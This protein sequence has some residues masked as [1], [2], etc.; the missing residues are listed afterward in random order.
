M[1]YREQYYAIIDNRRA[2]PVDKD[3]Y[4]ETHHIIPKSL[5]GSNEKGN[6][7]ALLPEEHY[8]CHC[9]LVFMYEH[10]NNHAAFVKMLHAWRFMANTGVRKSDRKR[11]PEIARMDVGASEYSA[12]RRK[13]IDTVI[14][15]IVKKRAEWFAGL[16]EEER[17]ALIKK[18]SDSHKGKKMSAETIKKI[19]EATTGK[20]KWSEEQK[21]E[22][23]RRNKI[24]YSDPARRLAISIRKKGKKRSPETI[25]KVR[26]AL[27]G[28]KQSAE[29][30]LKRTRSCKGRVWVHLGE[31]SRFIQKQELDS[32]IKQGYTPGVSEK[33]K[34]HMRTADLGTVHMHNG[35]RSIK[36]RP[37]K[38][39]EM[40]KLGF[41]LGRVMPSAMDKISTQEWLAALDG[42]TTLVSLY[43]K[44][45]L[46]RGYLQTKSSRES[47]KRKT[48]IDIDA[49]IAKNKEKL[50]L[51]KEAVE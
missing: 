4:T 32:F 12:I 8:K 3:V 10:E 44:L 2:N 28:R 15:H 31:I 5:G 39:D 40:L 43:K 25:E 38:V 1:T 17:A 26:N 21:A 11:F 9:L 34:E 29:L 35:I 37:E 16:S 30:V 13:F 20:P 22:I 18:L 46:T 45:G 49:V 33:I 48:G 6:L 47:V 27:L 41:V 19:K 7:V 14:P 23:S 24:L 42:T 36:V 50:K 51:A